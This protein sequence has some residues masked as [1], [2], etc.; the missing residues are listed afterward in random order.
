MVP[1]L[2][3]TDWTVHDI[4]CRNHLRTSVREANA[5]PLFDNLSMLIVGDEKQE[6][7]INMFKKDILPLAGVTT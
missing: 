5:P 2:L 6:Q 1:N 7:E 4:F 3:L